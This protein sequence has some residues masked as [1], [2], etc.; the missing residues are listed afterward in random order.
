M[1]I[2]KKTKETICGAVATALFC[3]GVAFSGYSNALAGGIKAEKTGERNIHEIISNGGETD[4]YRVDAKLVEEDGNTVVDEGYHPFQIPDNFTSEPWKIIPQDI[5]GDGEN[6]S[7]IKA[8]KNRRDTDELLV[9]FKIDG[10]LA[11]HYYMNRQTGNKYDGRASFD[12]DGN[13]EQE[14]KRATTGD[15]KFLVDI[16]D[17]LN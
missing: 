7:V 3:G 17:Y 5:N 2:Y 13:F 10:T 8:Y 6:E 1:D 12:P 15:L 11:I 4:F 16:E 9:L 14:Q